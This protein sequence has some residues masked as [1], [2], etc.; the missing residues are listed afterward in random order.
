MAELQ[1]KSL[2]IRSAKS[3]KHTFTPVCNELLQSE[4]LS[5]EARGLI[6]FILSLPENWNLLKEVVRKR[7]G[8]GKTKFERIWK[9]CKDAG[10]IV[11]HKIK[12]DNNQFT[13]WFHEVSDVQIIRHSGNLTVGECGDIEKKDT[14][15]ETQI[16]KE[17]IKT[18]L[19]AYTEELSN[20]ILSEIDFDKLTSDIKNS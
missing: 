2:I 1:N 18:A 19:S 13:G 20:K 10:Y 9:E 7:T 5:L 3:G 4:S 17:V 15:K 16:N 14:T 11:S 6:S 8:L 12:N